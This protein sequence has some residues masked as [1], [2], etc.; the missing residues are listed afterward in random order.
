MAVSLY[1]FPFL[2]LVLKQSIAQGMSLS[3]NCKGDLWIDDH[4]SAEDCALALGEAWRLA[5]GPVKGIKRFGSAYAPLD[6]VRY[7]TILICERNLSRTAGT[8]KSRSRHFLPTLL[9]N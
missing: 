3:I 9:C 2:S 4:H 7:S 1:H 8:I 6:E 5:L